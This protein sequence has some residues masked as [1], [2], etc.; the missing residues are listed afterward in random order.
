MDARTCA[1]HQ[2]TDL[3]VRNLQN[4]YSVCPGVCANTNT[5]LRKIS[6]WIP[7]ISSLRQVANTQ[8]RCRDEQVYREVRR[9]D[10]ERFRFGTSREFLQSV[11]FGLGVRSYFF[12][13]I[14]FFYGRGRDPGILVGL[15]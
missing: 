9:P 7:W 6:L 14:H 4:N 3:S 13:A 15:V 10:G 8:R 1:G 11:R 2:A 5:I 12:Q